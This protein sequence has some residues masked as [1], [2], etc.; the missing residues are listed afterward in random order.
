MEGPRFDDGDPDGARVDLVLFDDY[1]TRSGLASLATRAGV[2]LDETTPVAALGLDGAA[3]AALMAWS[4]TDTG[5]DEL[6]G[7]GNE[8]GTVGDLYQ[9]H[10][11]FRLLGG[12]DR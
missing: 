10:L 8:F 6:P 5:C 4:A 7:G 3:V 2:P 11:A 1:V 9:A 12:P